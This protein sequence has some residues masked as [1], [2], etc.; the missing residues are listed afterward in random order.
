MR[1]ALL[2]VL[3]V[4]PPVF[5]G[6]LA[7]QAGPGRPVALPAGKIAWD[8]ACKVNLIEAASTVRITAELTQR[9]AVDTDEDYPTTGWLLLS[10]GNALEPIGE[11]VFPYGQGWTGSP[12]QGWT[13]YLE[14][15]FVKAPISDLAAFVLTFGHD[16]TV[17]GIPRQRK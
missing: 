17:F 5:S 13:C 3:A 1:N 14:F 4:F 7:P 10:D 6:C 11:A 9:G 8:I 16:F 2:F 12:T 15:N